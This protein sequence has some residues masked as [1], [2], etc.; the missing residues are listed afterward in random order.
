MKRKEFC[1]A[2]EAYTL[3]LCVGN[4]P[5]ELLLLAD[6]TQEAIDKYLMLSDVYVLKGKDI[7]K[8][9]FCLFKISADVLELKNIAVHTTLQGKGIGSILIEEILTI[10]QGQGY[11]EL[12]VG[13]AT[14]GLDQ[15]RFYERNGF[16][17]YG[18]RE[19]FGSVSKVV[20]EL[21]RTDLCVI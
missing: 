11:K 16:I 2:G 5:Y 3:E 10:A 1:I 17:K 9:V 14:C 7:N 21:K 8:A 19:N 18:I 15:I 13:T 6:E 4:Y 12:I 20:F